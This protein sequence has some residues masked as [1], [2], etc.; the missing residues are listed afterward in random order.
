MTNIEWK[1]IPGFNERY[2]A[3]T[4]G[5]IRSHLTGKILVA[6]PDNYGYRSVSLRKQPSWPTEKSKVCVLVLETFVGP[7]P[8]EQ[9]ACHGP[10]GINC[11]YLD[12]LSW[13][14]VKENAE[15]RIRDGTAPVGEQ[16]P[17][18]KFTEDDVLTMRRAH[19]AGATTL[20]LAKKYECTRQAVHAIVI[21]KLWS[22]VGGPLH[23]PGETTVLTDTDVQTMRA[24]Y[25]A[26]GTSFVKL[27]S[28]H[29]VAPMTVWKAIKG[30]T[31]KTTEGAQTSKSPAAPRAAKGAGLTESEVV[32]IREDFAR[33]GRSAKQ[34]A[35]DCGLPYHTMRRILLHETWAAAGGP[36]TTKEQL[37]KNIGRSPAPHKA[38]MTAE[39]V[40]ESRRRYAVGG[41][42]IRALSVE[43]GVAFNA[44]H[45]IIRRKT[46]KHVK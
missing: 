30:E 15:D 39:Q 24:T 28:Q 38:K 19:K 14:T 45:S 11:D 2:S 5:E 46:W 42:T 18:A 3:S 8:V 21:G 10:R 7:R 4:R 17:G 12:N 23:V 20:E 35:V 33:G 34:M 26:G 40:I 25:A 36:K 29:G 43:Y 13:G 37:K 44:M 27:A 22:H 41:V 32:K 6:F 16:H 31:W 9:V 1:F